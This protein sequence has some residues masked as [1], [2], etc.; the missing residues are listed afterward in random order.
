MDSVPD[1]WRQQAT[2]SVSIPIENSI[3]NR[4]KFE[5]AIEAAYK[6]VRVKAA[7]AQER[8]KWKTE[9]L[10]KLDPRFSVTGVV[11]NDSTKY[12]VRRKPDSDAQITIKV[13]GA[14]AKQNFFA[15]VG[16]GRVVKLGPSD[17]EVTGSPL[18]EEIVKDKTISLKKQRSIEAVAVC[19]FLD[20]AGNV[21]STLNGVDGTL[22]GGTAEVSF[23]GSISGSPFSLFVGPLGGG[24]TAK[25]SVEMLFPKWQT[26][27]VRHLRYFERLST[28]FG[29]LKRAA[30]LRVEIFIG[31]EPAFLRQMP[32]SNTGTLEQVA[33]ACEYI[34]MARQIAS[35]VDTPIPFDWFLFQDEGARQY[36]KAMFDFFMSGVGEC[37]PWTG[38]VR[39]SSNCMSG[40][41]LRL[42]CRGE[43]SGLVVTGEISLQLLSESFSLG[44][45]A[46]EYLGTRFTDCGKSDGATIVE[47]SSLADSLFRIRHMTA[48]ERKAFEK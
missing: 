13:K 11:T 48:D 43:F 32:V 3:S 24:V 9:K 17:I 46:T 35:I 10:E 36:I 6:Y 38:A 27:P 26:T 29:G 31:D 22:I 4:D 1:G 41:Q 34:K 44:E 8:L 19:S 15:I 45:I 39:Y 18:I 23:S 20:T 25:I 14:N 30:T 40:D 12:S 5:H 33:M 37:K 7:T 21:E 16:Q 42:L 47:V 2:Y 28:F